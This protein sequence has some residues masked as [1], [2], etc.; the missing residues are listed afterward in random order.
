MLHDAGSIVDSE[1][2]L[3]AADM[4]EELEKIKGRRITD[5]E[6]ATVWQEAEKKVRREADAKRWAE[7]RKVREA[8]ERRDLQGGFPGLV[9][10]I[11]REP[12]LFLFA[13]VV[14]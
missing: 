13:L 12:K 3:A 9:R 1:V 10:M 4:E 2:F 5:A 11:R 7:E 14:L 8:E 6:A